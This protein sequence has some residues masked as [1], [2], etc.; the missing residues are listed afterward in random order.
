MDKNR[1]RRSEIT[2]REHEILMPEPKITMLDRDNNMF[3]Y[4]NKY[5]GVMA[6]STIEEFSLKVSEV[7]DDIGVTEELINFR[8]YMNDLN[9]KIEGMIMKDSLHYIVGS[10]SEGSTTLGMDS[11]SDALT[12]GTKMIA[13]LDLSK[14]YSLTD[15]ILVV[16]NPVS[17]PQ[18]CSLQHVGTFSV[19]PFIYSQ[20]EEQFLYYQN[21]R[22][23]LS[24]KFLP[25]DMVK[26]LLIKKG[27][28]CEQ[29]GPAVTAYNRDIVLSIYCPSLHDD[30][31]TWMIRPR[32]GH[33]P[34]QQTLENAKQCG[35]FL[36]HRGKIGNYFSHDS[37]RG[38]GYMDKQFADEYASA[39]WRMSTNKIEQMLVFDLNLVQMKTLILLK[40]V[41]KEFFKTALRGPI[42]HLSH[43]N[44][45]SVHSGAISRGHLGK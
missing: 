20:C 3:K 24:N 22:K 18:S 43:E 7:M 10:Q 26:E 16:K 35:M 37:V 11:D 14:R 17:F 41:R 21:G 25:K 15:T 39:Q 36:V 27:K 12:C 1:I 28:T 42:E 19:S 38:V 4:Q 30:C 44:G 2:I 13:I 6:A 33:W 31:L 8:M 34:K 9:E 32:P 29:N 23:M 40:M 45:F 5:V